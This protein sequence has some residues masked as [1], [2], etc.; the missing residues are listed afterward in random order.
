MNV[1]EEAISKADQLSLA[2]KARLLEH[3]SASMRHDLE[4]EA[5]NACLGVNLSIIRQD[6][7]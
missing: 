6:S 1:Y 7:C 4:V 2:E 5:L 3:I